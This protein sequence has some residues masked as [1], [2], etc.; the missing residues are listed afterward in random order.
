MFVG[1]AKSICIQWSPGHNSFPEMKG[2]ALIVPLKSVSN[3]YVGFIVQKC[4][5]KHSRKVTS[6]KKS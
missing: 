3:K 1:K 2:I 4:I 5:P 6:E